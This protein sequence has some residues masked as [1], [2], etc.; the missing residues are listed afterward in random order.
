[1]NEDTRTWELLTDVDFI[2]SEIPGTALVGFLEFADDVW[3]VCSHQEGSCDSEPSGL[4]SPVLHPSE[5]PD[6]DAIP[7]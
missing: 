5:P 6:W 4:S 1:M 2:G 3:L 7:F